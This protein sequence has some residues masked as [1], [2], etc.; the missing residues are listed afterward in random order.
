MATVLCNMMADYDAGLLEFF[1]LPTLRARFPTGLSGDWA[2][3]PLASTCLMARTL[4]R[5]R[6]RRNIVH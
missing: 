6:S 5:L 1:R 2:E 3:V 4:L